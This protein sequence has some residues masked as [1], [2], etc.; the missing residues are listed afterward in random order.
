MQNQLIHQNQQ[1]SSIQLVQAG[2][3]VYLQG[4]NVQPMTITSGNMNIQHPGIQMQVQPSLHASQINIQ[5]KPLNQGQLHTSVSMSQN[6][7]SKMTLPVVSSTANMNNLISTP[8]TVI[9]T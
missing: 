8:Q 5:P 1:N 9:S 3:Q 6:T 4:S 2:Q 7:E